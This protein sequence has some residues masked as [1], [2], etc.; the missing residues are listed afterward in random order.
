VLVLVE[1]VPA[2]FS[3]LIL[4]TEG[5]RGIPSPRA[6]GEATDGIVAEAAARWG[7]SVDRRP[8]APVGRRG[9]EDAPRFVFT[10]FSSSSFGG[11][12]FID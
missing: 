12:I 1:F 5:A 4:G 7:F 10:G 6:L 8:G 9:G 2:S 11:T 3:S